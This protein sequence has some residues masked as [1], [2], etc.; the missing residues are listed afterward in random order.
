MVCIKEAVNI[1]IFIYYYNLKCEFI[2][3]EIAEKDSLEDE[4]YVLTTEAPKIPEKPA[5]S[6]TEDVTDPVEYIC[7][8]GF[9]SSK[10]KCKIY[11]K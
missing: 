11:L 5:I 1:I 6:T 3:I 2:G 10:G 8:T 9:V 7:P 4:Y